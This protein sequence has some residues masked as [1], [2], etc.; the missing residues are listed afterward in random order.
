MDEDKCFLDIEKKYLQDAYY[1]KA[2]KKL[3]ETTKA[4]G[5]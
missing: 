1:V 3:G 2:A 4:S 5:S